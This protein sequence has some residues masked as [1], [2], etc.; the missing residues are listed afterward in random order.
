MLISKGMLDPLVS[1]FKLFIDYCL[2]GG[3][4]WSVGP[5]EFWS[6]INL[7]HG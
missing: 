5:A 3:V 2:L 6:K 4:V 1:L 7:S